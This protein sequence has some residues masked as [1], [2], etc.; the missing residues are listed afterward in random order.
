[1]KASVP[2]NESARL[3]ALRRFQVL[4][5][6][7]EEAFDRITRLAAVQLAVPV[8]LVSL[9]DETRQ[10][11]KSRYG[12]ETPE[13]PREW[14]FCAHA[15]ER[16][17]ALAVPDARCDPR[18]RDNPL[19]TGEPHIAGY[20]GAPLRLSDGLVLGSLCVLSWEPR[21]FTPQEQ[22]LLEGLAQV[23]VHLLEFRLAALSLIDRERASTAAAQDV[24]RQRGLALAASEERYRELATNLPGLV[25]QYRLSAEGEASLPYLSTAASRLLGVD[26]LRARNDPEQLFS[27]VVPP[28]RAAFD[29]ALAASRAAVSAWEWQGRLACRDGCVHWFRLSSTPRRDEGGSTLWHGIMLDVTHQVRTE[30]RLQQAQRMEAIGQLTGGIAHDFNNLLAVM[31]GNA[32]LL[33]DDVGAEHPSVKAIMR[34]SARGAELIERL[35]AFSRLRSLRPEP[36]DLGRAAR[37]MAAMLD[38]ILG[39]QIAVA[40]EVPPG[41]WLASVD[42][43]EVENALLNLAV[44]ARD[45]LPSGGRIVIRCSNVELPADDPG[46]PLEAAVGPHVAVSVIDNGQGMAAEVCERAVEPYFTTKPAGR[47]SGLGL[48]TVYGFVRQSGGH[49]RIESSLGQGTAVTLFF[50]RA[51]G[52]DA[53]PARAEA[54]GPAVAE[55]ARVLLL[56]DD[57]EVRQMAA[58]MLEEAGFRVIAVADADAARAA[59]DAAERLDLLLSDV[60][61]PDGA[62]GTAFARE[63]RRLHPEL[64]VVFMSG[65]P[66]DALQGGEA[67]PADAPLLRKP[68]QRSTLDATLRLAL[69]GGGA[70]GPG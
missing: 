28:D 12:L 39:R 66:A 44:N 47:S 18:F 64:K 16:T 2:E 29:R 11:F 60:L 52:A 22:A 36:V 3:A 6:P 37:D 14:A 7:A 32:E 15:L 31:Q 23:V 25:F 65:Y 43:G 1:M 24:S 58:R 56:E 68:F 17:T 21:P 57:R 40:A 8:A 35:Q 26:P 13:T 5:T 53:P 34:A 42:P 10:W 9:I 20:C 41:L 45:A 61:L 33:T 49:L 19:V 63:A 38:R 55:G 51:E 30:E 50:P 4:D 70:A 62:T 67:L 48:S 69:S 59:L 46:R 54:A 27:V